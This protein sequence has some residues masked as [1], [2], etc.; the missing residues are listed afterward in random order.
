MKKFPFVRQP[1]SK[2][3]GP[4]CL[5]SICR[6]YGKRISV[7]TLSGKCDVH[8]EGVS[9]LGLSKIARSLGFDTL[10]VSIPCNKLMLVDCPCVL[11]WNQNHYVVMYGIDMKREVFYI[12]DPAKGKYRLRK[13]EL[14]DHW[15]GTSNKGVALL[16]E[17]TDEFRSIPEDG[18]SQYSSIR[19][20]TGYLHEYRGYLIQ[21]AMGL[22]FMSCLQFVFPLFTQVVVD[23]GI[24]WHDVNLL[25]LIMAGWLILVCAKT[26]TEM[27]RRRLMLHITMRVNVSL[28][29]RFFIKL[30]KLP[31]HF[32][33]S[34]TIGDLTQRIGDHNRVQSFLTTQLLGA[35]FAIITFIVF[36]VIL[37]IYDIRIFL[38]FMTGSI[39]YA[40]WILFFL[41]RRKILDY[42]TFEIEAINQSKTYQF[43]S[44]IQEI[45]LNNCQRRRRWEWEDIQSDLFLI[46][47]KV[48]RLQQ[49]Q[50]SGT[51][52]ITETKN[53]VIIVVSAMLVMENQISIGEMMAIMFI[54]GQ[55]N[56]P[57]DHMMGL[58]YSIQDM[59]LSLERI[60][61]VHSKEG[62][63][64]DFGT[65]SYINRCEIEFEHVSFRYDR[66][67]PVYAVKDISFKVDANKITAIV[68][69][70]GSG[71]TTLMKLI[72]GYYRNIDGGIYLSGR[73]LGEYDVDWLRTRF[74]VVMQ[75]GFIFTESIARNIAVD[76]NEIDDDRLHKAAEIANIRDYIEN[77]PHGYD[78]I[79]GRDGTGLSQGQRQRILIARAVYKNPDIMILDE[80]TNALDAAN[81]RT[82]VE[83]LTGY[84]K[85]RTVIVIAHRLST[86][87]NADK[88]VV[89]DHGRIVESGQHNELISKNGYYYNLIKNQI[90]LSD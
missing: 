17:P 85:N 53:T 40:V 88:I 45:K 48:L 65:I 37:L 55:L 51:I 61:D 67:S 44:A 83:N 31:M 2:H 52:F 75:D 34:M 9:I 13:N 39:L 80:A 6:H 32:F 74:G 27:I 30:M 46:K 15:L 66:H 19:V 86:V 90:E 16:L 76:D 18:D 82:I 70:S 49:I 78:T 58:L 59:R 11:H 64:S 12:C 71:K 47:Q 24:R 54:V 62:E 7:H 10:C 8:P 36:S 26:L 23:V 1:D 73:D 57:L 72:L 81:E 87:R 25:W 84:C 28:I 77:L 56:T 3:C 5:S 20:V 60:N 38:I 42:E 29:S 43:L 69:H 50:E 4:A 63:S 89:M 35:V 21:M 41:Q 68:G 79:I 14:T 33:E 22:L